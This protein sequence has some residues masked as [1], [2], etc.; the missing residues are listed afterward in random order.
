[1]QAAN[2]ATIGTDQEAGLAKSRTSFW[3]MHGWLKWAVG[4]LLAAAALLAG[5]VTVAAHRAEPFLRARIVEGLRERFHARVELDSF[6]VSLDNGLDGRWGVWAEGKGLRIWPPAQVAGVSVPAGTSQPNTPEAPL[7]RLKVFRFHAPLRYEPG[8][9]IRVSVVK[10]TGLDVDLPPRSHFLHNS[11]AAEPAR[12]EEASGGGL[13]FEADSIEC[14]DARLI[15]ETGK[16]GKLPLKIAIA[17]LKLTKTDSDEQLSAGIPA[18]RFDAELTSPRPVGTIHSKGRFGPWDVADPGESPVSGDYGFE[19]ADLGEFKGIAGILSSIGHYEGTLRD[20]T[21]DGETDTPDFRLKPF[22]NPLA[23]HTTFHAKVDGTNGDTWLEPVEATLGHSHFTAQ[24]QI[25]RAMVAE[26]G[27]VP[28]SIG[29]DIALNVNVDRGR[30]EDF[31]RLAS[32]SGTPLL[33]GAVTVKA[34]LDISPGAAPVHERMRL[35]GAF[36]LEQAQFSSAKIQKGIEQLSARGLGHPKDAKKT[37][38]APVDSTMKGDFQMADGTITLPSLIYTVPGATI[39]LKGTYAVKGGALDFTGTAKTDA[40]VSEMVG[41]WK[42]LLLSPLDRHFEKDGAGTEIPIHINGTREKPEFG[43]DL[44]RI[45][46]TE[47]P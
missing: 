5:I 20:L 42:G 22:D 10:L 25:V 16:P 2:P 14:K 47:A 7:I 15:L 19:H 18:M 1:M 31:L 33:T 28:Q 34:K 24:G 27:S 8:K 6:H 38:A 4:G 36:A 30:I 26:P 40:T 46:L 17:H 43:L 11:T 37:D 9:P 32:R 3:R 12:N 41:G 21:V 23:L 13:R 35:Q 45:K 44:G 39:Q 29:H